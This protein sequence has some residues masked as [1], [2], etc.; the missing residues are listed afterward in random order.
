MLLL[1]L[2]S[3]CELKEAIEALKKELFETAAIEGFFNKRAVEISQ[4]IKLYQSR[5][6]E[7]NSLKPVRFTS[8]SS[9]IAYNRRTMR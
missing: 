1:D 8:T 2:M 6:N 5:Y 4:R 7:L 3:P 9:S